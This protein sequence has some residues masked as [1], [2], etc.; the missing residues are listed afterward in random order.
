[1]TKYFPS[2]RSW[3]LGGIIWGIL[4]GVF[5][6]SLYTVIAHFSLTDLIIILLIFIILFLFFGIVWFRTGYFISEDYLIIKIGPFTHSRV[7]ISSISK[8]LRSNSVLSS[9]ANSLNRL[10]IKYG[11]KGL[12][13][14]SP[15]DEA[16]FIIAIKEE[17]SKVIV[18]I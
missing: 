18:N 17:N 8:I 7:R 3:V 9:P 12:V 15:K 2:A 5:G 11:R 4:S 14:I 6:F 16:D 13:L 10:S 1:M